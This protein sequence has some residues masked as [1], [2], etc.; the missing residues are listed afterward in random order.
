MEICWTCGWVI[1]HSHHFP[2][3]RRKFGSHL[4]HPSRP[5]IDL[6][7]L[8]H[9]R[10]E[11]SKNVNEIEMNQSRMIQSPHKRWWNRLQCLPTFLSFFFLSLIVKFCSADE[12]FAA[13]IAASAIGFGP[14]IFSVLSFFSL[15]VTSNWMVEMSIWNWE[16][17][18][19]FE[20]SLS[21]ENWRNCSYQFSFSY[22]WCNWLFSWV[23]RHP[24]CIELWC[25]TQNDRRWF[26]TIRFLRW[27]RMFMRH[28]CG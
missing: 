2:S 10:H 20:S 5:E 23:N 13:W 7:T 12:A 18:V 25:T 11:P 24:I 19:T 3:L 22:L 9:Q 26:R 27:S 14:F 4:H 28:E 21:P 8:G 1:R 17:V 15:F 6:P 16:F